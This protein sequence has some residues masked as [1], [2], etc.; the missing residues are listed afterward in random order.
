MFNLEK[1]KIEELK[2]VLLSLRVSLANLRVQIELANKGLEAV[3]STADALY[4]ELFAT[5]VI[6]QGVSYA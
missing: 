6:P 3:G 5:P 2:T 1:E 4:E